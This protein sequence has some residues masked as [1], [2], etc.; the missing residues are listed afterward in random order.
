MQTQASGLA[1]RLAEYLQNSPL[2]T[3]I[4]TKIIAKTVTMPRAMA[5]MK[6]HWAAC[7]IKPDKDM[8][9]AKIVV[10]C[11]RRSE[12]TSIALRRLTNAFTIHIQ[13][14]H[15]EWHHF[16][17]VVA[18]QH[19]FKTGDKRLND[20]D[21]KPF[22]SLGA[23]HNITSER[24]AAARKEFADPFQAMKQPRIAVL[25]GGNSR[26]HRLTPA[27][28]DYLC[29]TLRNLAEDGAGLMISFS[30]RTPD[31]AKKQITR[32]LEAYHP[33]IWPRY[34]DKSPPPNPYRGL[35]AWADYILVTHD[36]AS[37][38]SEATA[39]Q[40]PVYL[41]PLKGTSKKFDRF[42]DQMIAAGLVRKFDGKLENWQPPALDETGRIAQ[43]LA[44]RIHQRISVTLP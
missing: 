44:E 10:S 20:P 2:N 29:Q 37:M 21:I 9:G 35:L 23:V 27:I 4:D 16:D 13:S 1:T 5:W 30:R 17:A 42:H 38:V 28:A 6:P 15:T 39:A 26:T 22:I 25:I 8:L 40:K 12:A 36:S 19:D 14:P 24:L 34:D 32:A 18:P 3:K 41:L 33:Y 43:I 11:G 7:L 31:L